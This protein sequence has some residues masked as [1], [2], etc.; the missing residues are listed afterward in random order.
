MELYISLLSIA[1]AVISLVFAICTYIKG[2]IHNRKQST[3]DAFNVL[4]EQA[5]DELNNYTT[6]DIQQALDN[7]DK[8]T[9]KTINRC[10]ARIEHFSVGVNQKI[11]DKKTVYELAH[12]YIDLA[13]WKKLK[14]VIEKKTKRDNYYENYLT[15]VKNMQER[16]K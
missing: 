5:L 8:D 15:M 12:G 14:P 7:N 2:V 6:K 3:L 4:Q 11:Y 10:L 9:M 1:V 13:I 16:N